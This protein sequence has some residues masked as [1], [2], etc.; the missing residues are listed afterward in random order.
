[1]SRATKLELTYGEHALGAAERF[2]DH[3]RMSQAHVLHWLSQFDDP[4]LPLAIRLLERIR[5]YN[6][7]NI[8]TLCRQLVSVILDTLPQAE[9]PLIAVVPV[10]GPGSGS[11]IMARI[12]RD[13]VHGTRC[14]LV[15]TL[16]LAQAKAGDFS[17]LVF[18][19]DFSGSGKTLSDWWM[20]VEPLVRP[21][22]AEIVFGLLVLNY[23]A[24]G[25]VQ[26][27]ASRIICVEELD[28]SADVFDDAC[29]DFDEA[30]KLVLLEYS[31]RTGCGA[32]YLRGFGDCGLI[33]SFR[34]G[35]PNNSIP[36]LWHAT[37]SWRALFMRRAV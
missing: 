11:A 20:S 31:R 17:A 24:R 1:M 8:R 2:G 13:A 29:G 10:G 15:Q 33:L 26:E 30:E 22:D 3:E 4:H 19:D 7:L 9:Y 14:R 6:T 37:K 25:P 27:F 23:R 35:C 21:L 32:K 18:I 34:Y 28:E 16:Q 5:Y 36:S 12:V